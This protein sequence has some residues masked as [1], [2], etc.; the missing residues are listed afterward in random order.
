MTPEKIKYELNNYIGKKIKIKYSLGRNKFEEYE[1]IV[2]ELY[3]HIFVV[4]LN[5]NNNIFFKS[6]S[7]SDVITKTIKLNL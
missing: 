6:F 5:E 1:A 2:K 4:E 7:Y 3:N